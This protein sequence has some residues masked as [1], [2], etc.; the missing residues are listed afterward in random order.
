MK[1]FDLQP[2]ID[3]MG[4]KKSS[5]FQT[6]DLHGFKADEIEP[7]V[8]DFLYSMSQK[9]VKKVA[10]MTGKGTGKVQKIVV[11]YLKKANYPWSFE[12]QDNGKKNTGVLIIHMD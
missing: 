1:L 12:Q 4:K 9:G 2:N 3:A 8:D 11:N 6:L 5:K 7:K 10:I